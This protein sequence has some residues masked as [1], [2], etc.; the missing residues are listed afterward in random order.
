V[1]NAQVCPDMQW[2]P[3]SEGPIPKSNG[4]IHLFSRILYRVAGDLACPGARGAHA[5]MRTS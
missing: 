1:G 3:L 5:S 2:V 4:R